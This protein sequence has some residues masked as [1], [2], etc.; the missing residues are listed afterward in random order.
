M[1]EIAMKLSVLASLLVASTPMVA[2][3][4]PATPDPYLWLED[5]ASP[6]AMTWVEAH[7]AMTE[8]ALTADPHYAETLAQALA[9]AGAQDRIP[10]PQQRHGQ[11]FNFWTDQQHLRGI[12]RQTTLADYRK[13]EPHW[14]TVLDIDALGKAEGKSWVYRGLTCLQPEQ[15]LCLVQLSDGGEDAEELR[16]FDLSTGQFVAGGFHL[17]RGKH[18]VAWEDADHLLV[19]T[20]WAPGEL[21]GSGYPFIVKRLTRGHALSEAV[22]VMRGSK[23]DGGYGVNPDV[24]VDGRN[25][26]LELVD[27]PLDTFHQE[28]WV[29]TPGGPRRLAIPAKSGIAGLVAGQVI[30]QLDEDWPAAGPAFVAGALAS[31]P[32][33]TV[34]AGDVRDPRLIWAPGPK[35][36]L[37]GTATTRDR[38]LVNTLDNVRGVAW[39]YAPDAAGGWT[40][41]RLPL[42]QDITLSLGSSDVASN[43]AFAD[44]SGFLTPSTLYWIDAE[45]LTAEAIKALPA[46][47]DA[48]RDVVE[49]LEAVSSDGTRVPYFVVHRKGMAYDGATPTLLYA[50]G[51]FAISETPGYSANIGK[52]WLEQGGAYVLAN[53]RGGGEFGPKWHDAGLGVKRQ[54]I[55]DDF[56]AVARDLFSRKITSPRRLGI[57]GGSNGGLLMGVEFTQHPELWNAVVI[58][59]PLLDMIRISRIAAG[60]SW[61][62]EYGDVNADPAA[63]AF[64]QKTSPYQALK[65]GGAYPEP[66]IFTTTKDDRVGPQHA[67]KFAARMEEYHLPFY[68]YENTEGGHG[69]GADIKQAA[70]VTALTMTYLRRKLIE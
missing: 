2:V 37:D 27:R 21:T 5:V 56:A 20:E 18:R 54:I 23:D 65:P 46:K 10:A 32:L 59:V 43:Q 7:N 15:R 42:P 34:G 44:A 64:W 16:E 45:R 3:A 61:Q 41:R 39:S 13:A 11:I 50:Y 38:L 28:V 12:L 63:M 68:F 9:L 22:E 51:G 4:Q 67:R 30:V 29:I 49:Q 47:F 66:F 70:K 36:A 40:R 35:E 62:G 25:H 26:R 53:I 31:L 33:A 58:Q 6:R 52:L 60:A 19:A 55:Y 17:L 69:A 24:F 14:T 48:S 1:Q 57:E 8:K